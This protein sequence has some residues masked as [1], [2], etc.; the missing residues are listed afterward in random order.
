MFYIF[1][2]LRSK[3]W[4][5]WHKVFF[6]LIP[7]NNFFQ[8]MMLQN[9]LD[10]NRLSLIHSLSATVEDT[11]LFSKGCTKLKLTHWLLSAICRL[12]SACK[13]M[14]LKVYSN[15][16][17]IFV[18]WIPRPVCWIRAETCQSSHDVQDMKLYTKSRNTAYKGLPSKI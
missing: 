18:R 1:K 13:M 12:Y 3:R 5:Q 14:L 17:V 7:G 4:V 16:S 2:Q 11:G 10:I 15:S 8:R 9:F 6:S